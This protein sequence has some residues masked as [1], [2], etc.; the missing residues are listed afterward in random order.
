MKNTIH[1]VLM[2]MLCAFVGS[3]LL[4]LLLFIYHIIFKFSYL[5]MAPG[6]PF[7]R[8]CLTMVF[9]LMLCLM[10]L[11]A[12]VFVLIKLSNNIAEMHKVDA[13][14]ETVKDTINK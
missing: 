7:D 4:F 9:L 6:V 3:V 14:A 5:C 12:L 13:D 11:V 1:Y 8:L 2:Y 10:N